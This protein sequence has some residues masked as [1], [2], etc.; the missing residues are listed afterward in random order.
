MFLGFCRFAVFH[1]FDVKLF[2]GFNNRWKV[3]QPGI[4]ATKRSGIRRRSLLFW[5]I[6]R[7]SRTEAARSTVL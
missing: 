1:K 5:R 2:I 6:F 3:I 7:G 4:L